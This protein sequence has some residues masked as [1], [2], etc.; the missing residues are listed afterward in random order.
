MQVGHQGLRPPGGHVQ[1]VVELRVIEELAE[2]ALAGGD[3]VRDVVK[4]V[5][6]GAEVRDDVVRVEHDFFDVGLSPEF[7]A[8]LVPDV[9]LVE[10]RHGQR[11]AGGRVQ[12][13]VQRRARAH[14]EQRRD[15]GVRCFRLVRLLHSS[16]A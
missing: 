9:W 8:I 12:A 4:L 11:A 13:M 7:G 10:V 15:H 14:L 16:A 6:Q 5:A 1:A 2:R 3:L